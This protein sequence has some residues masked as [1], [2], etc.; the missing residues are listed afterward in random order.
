MW[1]ACR[2]R[3]GRCYGS[4]PDFTFR[5]TLQV[6]GREF[7]SLARLAA[8]HDLSKRAVLERLLWWADHSVVQSFGEDDAA[9]NR[10]INIV[11]KNS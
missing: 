4:V 5:G 8:H 7:F 2:N 10:Y 9:F 1:P 11:T 6:G 3:Q